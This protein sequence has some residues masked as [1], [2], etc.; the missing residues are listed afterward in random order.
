MM[1]TV[2]GDEPR[3]NHDKD[4]FLRVVL[5]HVFIVFDLRRQN[6]DYDTHFDNISLHE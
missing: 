6:S 2:V 5:F 3:L 4:L 1:L